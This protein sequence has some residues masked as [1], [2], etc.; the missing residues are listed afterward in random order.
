M[1][2]PNR[3]F[4]A[5][6]SCCNAARHC[7]LSLHPRNRVIPE[8]TLCGTNRPY[9]DAA[10]A[11]AA[12]T[13]S[14]GEEYSVAQHFRQSSRSNRSSAQDLKLTIRGTVHEFTSSGTFETFVAL[15]PMTGVGAS[16]QE[17]HQATPNPCNRP[18]NPT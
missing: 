6:S 18:L 14:R 11:H 4:T 17:R 7:G 12:F 8:F 5:P 9:A 3:P 1:D 2:G 10:I 16:R 13:R 15:A